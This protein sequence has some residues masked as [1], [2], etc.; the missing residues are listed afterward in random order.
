MDI[1]HPIGQQVFHISLSKLGHAIN[2]HKSPKNSYLIQFHYHY[3]AK[4]K[5]NPTTQCIHPILFKA[6]DYLCLAIFQKLM[7]QVHGKAILS[8]EFKSIIK[9]HGLNPWKFI[10]QKPNSHWQYQKP[11]SY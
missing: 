8:M 3:L 6:Q 11:N 5:T 7:I 10:Y 9:V 2:H 4:S 1:S